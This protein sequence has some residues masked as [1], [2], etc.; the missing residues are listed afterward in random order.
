MGS[1][2]FNQY[3]FDFAVEEIA[4]TTN[5]SAKIEEVVVDMLLCSVNPSPKT[6]CSIDSI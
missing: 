2:L 1:I 5:P 3:V 4:T 6:H